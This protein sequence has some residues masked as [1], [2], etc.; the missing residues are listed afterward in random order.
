MTIRNLT[1]HPIRLYHHDTPDQVAD[2]VEP[3]EVWEPDG[4]PVRIATI[5][6][7]T[8]DIGVGRPVEFVEYGHVHDLPVK[9]GGVWLVVPLVVAL[10][11][12]GRDDLLVAYREVRNQSGTVVGCRHLARPV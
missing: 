11:T 5:D 2:D 10:A 1:P 9:Q 3:I 8:N 6:L 12:S 4:K 7:G